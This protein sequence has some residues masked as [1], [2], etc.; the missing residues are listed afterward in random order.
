[1]ISAQEL[2]TYYGHDD[3]HLL[4]L[5]NDRSKLFKW[6]GNSGKSVA[7]TGISL[8]TKEDGLSQQEAPRKR[9]MFESFVNRYKTDEGSYMMYATLGNYNS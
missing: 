5:G 6:Y 3:S 2:I 9:N 8:R 1:M 4:I 7:I